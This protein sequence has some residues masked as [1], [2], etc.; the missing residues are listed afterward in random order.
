ML[1]WRFLR[2]V[3][4]VE[5][6]SILIIIIVV[7]PGAWLPHSAAEGYRFLS[8]IVATLARNA[9][10]P[11]VLRGCCCFP[12]PK[13]SNSV[14]YCGTF[15]SGT[16]TTP[17]QNR[18][19]GLSP[20]KKS[21]SVQYC[22]TFSFLHI[23][24]ILVCPRS[25]PQPSLSVHIMSPGRLQSASA[26]SQSVPRAP[27]NVPERV[28]ALPEL[29]R[30]LPDR[31]RASPERAPS[32]PER[33]SPLRRAVLSR[34]RAFPKR[35]QGVSRALP[36]LLRASKERPSTRNPCNSAGH[37]HFCISLRS[38]CAPEAVLSRP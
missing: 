9:D 8:N 14:Q 11:S 35:R 16:S 12:P 25:C 15:S 1:N 21:K 28:R 3:L 24:A 38:W 33:A 23:I 18:H 7:G 17:M 30:A 27:Q 22:G 5:Y 19:F 6:Y 26:A 10:P 36:Q 31:P 32:T 29:P 4:K 13:K 34:L 2:E 20:H 37:F